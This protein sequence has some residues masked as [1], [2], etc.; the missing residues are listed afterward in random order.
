[1]LQENYHANTKT[2]RLIITEWVTLLS[3]F[4][5]CFLFLFSR[6]EKLSDRMDSAQHNFQ[7]SMSIHADRSDK[8]YEMFID[9]LRENRNKDA[10]EY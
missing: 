4:V 2:H 6:I 5:G 7:E 9:L 10:K 8:I 3:V 1:M